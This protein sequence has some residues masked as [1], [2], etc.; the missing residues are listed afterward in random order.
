MNSPQC[1]SHDWEATDALTFPG[2]EKLLL[3][4]LPNWEFLGLQEEQCPVLFNKK[5]AAVVRTLRA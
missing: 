1:W 4:A 3:D 5:Q 2:G